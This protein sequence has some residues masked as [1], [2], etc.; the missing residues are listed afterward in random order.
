VSTEGKQTKEET[1]EMFENASGGT[2]G[3][4]EG[5]YDVLEIGI[6]GY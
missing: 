5:A 4:M 1:R 2:M 6:G 3:Y